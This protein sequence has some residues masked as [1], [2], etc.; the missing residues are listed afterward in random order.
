MKLFNK[1]TTTITALSLSAAVFFS[2]GGVAS[3]TCWQYDPNGMTTSTTPVFNNICGVPNGTGDEANFVKIRPNTTGDDTSTSNNAAYVDSLNAACSTGDKFDVHTYIHNDA[4]PTQ[5]NNGSGTAVAH[6]VQLSLAAPVG[7]SASNFTF[8]STVTA[9]NAAT[10]HDTATLNCNGSPVKLTL[11]PG[12]VKIYGTQY[13]WTG[14]PDNSVNGTFK[15]G[16]PIIGSGDVWGCW[17]YRIVVVYEVQ[18]ER[19]QP[20]AAA[21]CTALTLVATEPRKVTVSNFTVTQTNAALKSVVLDWGD[22]NKV[23]L[24]SVD[25]VKGQTHTYAADGTYMVTAVA[26]FSAQGQADI[27]SGGA[28][29][30]CAQQVVFTS[31]QPPKVTPPPTTPTKLVNTGAGSV[32]GL[33]TATT[34]AGAAVYRKMLARKLSRQ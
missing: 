32:A 29:T 4:E 1:L 5:N 8:G 11:V 26:T 12:T 6:G 3:A 18:V 24:D 7:T 22:N 25:S 27:V 16:S 10:V 34:L 14:L 17:E 31:N 13:P 30:A 20:P 15:I 33:F 19:V 2:L 9:T 23:T 28:G 21:Q